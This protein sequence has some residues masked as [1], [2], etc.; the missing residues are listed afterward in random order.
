MA[1]LQFLVFLVEICGFLRNQ[2]DAVERERC[3]Y[4]PFPGPLVPLVTL[5]AQYSQNFRS[6][7]ERYRHGCAELCPDE[8]QQILYIGSGLWEEE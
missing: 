3:G 4:A 5:A 1:Y 8:A 2:S 6:K 7:H